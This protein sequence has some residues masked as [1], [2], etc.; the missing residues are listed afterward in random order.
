MPLPIPIN[1]HN[2]LT[3]S[4]S[5]LKYSAMPRHTPKS[6]RPSLILYTFLY[7]DISTHHRLN[8]LPKAETIG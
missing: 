1:T 2:N 5:I 3:K 6:T 7:D 4:G 8:H